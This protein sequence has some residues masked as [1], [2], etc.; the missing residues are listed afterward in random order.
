MRWLM[1]LLKSKVTLLVLVFGA[2]FGLGALIGGQFNHTPAIEPMLNQGRTLNIL[3]MGIDARD[4]KSNSRSDTMILASIN[5]KTKKVAMISIPR[6]THI[7]NSFGRSDKINSV[8]YVKG[9]EAACEEVGKLLDTRVDYYVVTNFAGFGK[10]VDAL[11]GVHIN[12]ENDMH[13]ADPINPELAINLHKGYQYM[14]GK[15]ALAY[16]RYRG[17]PTAD[18]GRTQRQQQFIKALAKEMVQAKTVLKLPKLLPEIRKYIHTN[19]PFKDMLY[20]AT[21]AKDFEDSGAI[22][23][24]TLPGYPYTDPSTGASYWEVDRETASTIIEDLLKGKKFEIVS[25]PPSWLEKE[26]KSKAVPQQE[27]IDEIKQEEQTQTDPIDN[28]EPGNDVTTGDTTNPNDSGNQDGQTTEPGNTDVN[29]G[30]N[31]DDGNTTNPSDPT[32]P[33]NPPDQEQLPPGDT[34]VQQVPQYNVQ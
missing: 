3:F 5:T 33:I 12:V 9:P 17:G 30:D 22:V 32:N 26:A 27:I 8:N 6:D 16:V 1:G 24:Q 31:T 11:G 20:L 4:T 7:K 34:P 15:T 10:I 19:I 29:T 13:H 18:I 23:A 21:V 25:D 2:T 14:D 28:G